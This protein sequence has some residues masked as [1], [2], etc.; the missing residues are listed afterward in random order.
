MSGQCFSTHG[1]IFCKDR[2]VWFL[3]L[4][5]RAQTRTASCQASWRST[6]ATEMLKVRCRRATRGFKRLRFSLR[7]VQPGIS[8]CIVNSPILIILPTGCELSTASGSQ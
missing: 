2:W 7:E 6:S 4:L 3:S 5:T 1:P 8:K